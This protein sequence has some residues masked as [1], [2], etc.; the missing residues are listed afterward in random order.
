MRDFFEM[1]PAPA[2]HL[3]GE[4]A[5]TGHIEKPTFPPKSQT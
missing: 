4:T 5:T 3:A 1:N 2:C